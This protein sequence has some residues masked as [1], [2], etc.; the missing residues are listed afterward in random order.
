M[1]RMKEGF[2]KRTDVIT[3]CE[4]CGE[5]QWHQK[6]EGIGGIDGIQYTCTKCQEF[7]VV[8]NSG[9]RQPPIKSFF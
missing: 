2:A 1:P 5:S 6:D 9:E 3:R 7:F 4:Y 8:F